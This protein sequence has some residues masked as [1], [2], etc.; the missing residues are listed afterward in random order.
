[1]LLSIRYFEPGKKRAAGMMLPGKTPLPLG[2]RRAVG[3]AEKSPVRSA[4]VR[5]LTAVE[6]GLCRSR[7]PWYEKKKNDLFLP[8]YTF[9]R[10]T[11]PPIVA[12]A[13]LRLSPS[14]CFWFGEP[15]FGGAKKLAALKAL[16]RTYQKATPCRSL[17]P[18]FVMA[19]TMPPELR[20][21]SALKLFVWTLNSW[22]ASG[23]GMG[24]GAL[25]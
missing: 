1:M 12:P 18:D 4:G 2:S 24:F 22:S 8:L 16:L 7:V 6:V 13:W 21:N 20:P 14:S 10:N 17:V 25:L 19:L 5:T 23:F 3:Y 9:G 15:G 11:G